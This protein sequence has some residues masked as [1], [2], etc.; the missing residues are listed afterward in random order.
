[1]SR[2]PQAVALDLSAEEQAALQRLLR[3]HGTGQALAQRARIILACGQSG[4]TN[5]GVAR[6]LGVSRQTVALW[7]GRFAA[8]R[9]EGL[10]DAPRSGA[11]RSIDDAAVERLVA[12][13]LE[14][15]PAN[16]THWSTRTMARRTGMSQTAVSRIWRAF[17]LRPHRADTFKLSTDPAFVEKVR[18][19]VGLYLAPPDR[20]LVLCVDEKPQIQAVQGT[21]PAFPL[22]PGQAERVTHDY[23]RHG[24][25]DLFAALDVKAGTVIGSCKPRHRSAEFRTFLE[26]VERS[27]AADLEVHLVLDNL[28]THKTKLIH[29]W[30]L[31][32]PRFHLH[33]TPTSASWLNLVE[34][35]FS[36]LSRRRLER[37]AF[38]STEDLEAAIRDYITETNA[39]PKPFVW[40][41]SADAILASVGRFC[42]QTSNSDH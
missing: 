21:A 26:Q 12:L 41:K 42:K 31:Q 27:V 11:P 19:V 30:L 40:T 6:S 7:R 22:R 24:T 25:L 28:K 34:C 33:F 18:D 9:L 39:H 4:A 32:H 15:A 36:V 14:E 17:G 8:H 20:A 29:D 38:T 1:M 10:V 13:T 16:A 2:G 23:R 37:G 3:R 5:L 35:W